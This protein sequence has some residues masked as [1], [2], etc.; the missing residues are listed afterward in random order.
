MEESVQSDA[1]PVWCLSICCLFHESALCFMN[2]ALA[3]VSAIAVQ[4]EQSQEQERPEL[5]DAP[6][7]TAP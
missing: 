4:V 6:F 7:L 2:L 1:L 3:S 5:L